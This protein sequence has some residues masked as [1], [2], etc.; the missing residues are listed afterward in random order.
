M[1]LNSGVTYFWQVL[2]NKKHWLF[3]TTK[4]SWISMTDYRRSHRQRSLKQTGKSRVIQ[5][6]L[7]REW[8]MWSV[9]HLSEAANN[10]PLSDTGKSLLRIALSP[11]THT[12]LQ[13]CV[14][15]ETEKTYPLHQLSQSTEVSML[16]Q[17]VSTTDFNKAN[18]RH[19]SLIC[20]LDTSFDHVT[21][22]F[23]SFLIMMQDYF[24]NSLNQMH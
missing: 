13:A 5:L 23:C 4:W 16:F 6:R 9:S 10:Q 24:K 18:S 21:P 12:V 15:Q 3:T 7:S 19:A 1:F 14:I 11:Q 8:H 17:K 20:S 22:W 2:Q